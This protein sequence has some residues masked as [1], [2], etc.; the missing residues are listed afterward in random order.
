[1]KSV[2]K[3]DRDQ[4]HKGV[5]ASRKVLKM[6]KMWADLR[7]TEKRGQENLRPKTPHLGKR[8]DHLN[9]GQLLAHSI[10]A[11]PPHATGIDSLINP[12]SVLW[13]V[14]PN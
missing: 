12:A 5:K 4:T 11:V 7:M 8:I 1:M 10:D 3:L 9:N 13:I 14:V 2:N 6:G